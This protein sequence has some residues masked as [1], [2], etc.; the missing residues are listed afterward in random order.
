ME[1]FDYRQKVQEHLDDQRWNIADEFDEILCDYESNPRPFQEVHAQVSRLFNQDPE[2]L[3]GFQEFLLDTYP[4]QNAQVLADQA[5]RHEAHRGACERQS[6]SPLLN[7]PREIRDKI[8][9][10]VALGNVVHV[11][12]SRA[13][14]SFWGRKAGKFC[15]HV[16]RA[17]KGAGSSACPP[18]VGDHAN[19]SI[20]GPSNYPD[21][22]LTC[23][24][25]LLELPDAETTFSSQTAFQF[26]DLKT[27]DAFLFGL[28]EPQRSSITHLKL[29]LPHNIASSE[30]FE[31]WNGILN[32]F[33]NPWE[34]KSLHMDPKPEDKPAMLREPI[35]FYYSRCYYENNTERMYKRYQVGRGG[36]SWDVG[37]S[38]LKYKGEPK[39]DLAMQVVTSGQVEDTDAATWTADLDSVANWCRPLL[40]FRQ[41]D[42]L[43]F[44]LYNDEGLTS[45]PEFEAFVAALKEHMVEPVIGPR[46]CMFFAGGAYEDGD[47]SYFALVGDH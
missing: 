15:F 20:T 8:W 40:Q 23:K 1:S 21:I 37:I 41:Y 18:G 45:T 2:L 25:F 35:Y 12:P 5:E 30:N 16:C 28:S 38:D 3:S 22:R 33:S 6:N 34:R 24:Q 29:A 32:Y 47:E 7:L 44:H 19:C 26:A 13:G 10:E 14:W 27:A 39:L 11:S 4:A 42:G 36:W 43:T 17:E 46:K 31:L 9:A